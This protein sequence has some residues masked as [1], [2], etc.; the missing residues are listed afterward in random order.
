MFY[1]LNVPYTTN[2]GELQ[3]TLA[4]HA[5]LGYNTVVLSHTINGKLPG[6][7]TSPI[8]LP[9]PFPTS[10]NLH[11]LTRCTL[12]L[13]DPS[14]NHRLASLATNYDLLALRPTSEK[15]LQ[16]AC[17]HLPANS[18]DLISLDCS[19][20]YPFY[21]KHKPLLAAVDRGIR[22]EI[23]YA[24]GIL[25]TGDQRRNL[26]S[27]A[28]QLIR[29]TRGRGVVVSSEASRALACRGPWDVVNLCQ[30]WGLGRERGVEA[31]E[32]ESRAVVVGAEMRK[33]SFKGVVDVVFGGEKPVEK[34]GAETE[35][36]GKGQS[37]GTQNLKRKAEDEGVRNEAEKPLSKREM[38][39]RA[40]KAR[41]ETAVTQ[42]AAAAKENDSPMAD[43]ENAVDVSV[44][45]TEGNGPVIDFKV[46]AVGVVLG[47]V[48]TIALEEPLGDTL[49]DTAAALFATLVDAIVWKVDGW[50]LDESAACEVLAAIWGSTTGKAAMGHRH[51]QSQG[52]DATLDLGDTVG[53]A[54]D[55]S[56]VLA[57]V[58]E[59][60]IAGMAIDVESIWF[61]P[62]VTTDS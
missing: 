3:R 1:D 43:L 29:A 50:L 49:G 18:V 13:S 51:E 7:L 33:K 12:H 34:K 30:A 11:L 16:S 25:G 15:A 22:I 14:Q 23:C 45:I 2:Q 31:I 46:K 42:D 47:L 41:M 55:D 19:I 48:I 36:K 56:T 17:I 60:G 21:F 39:R 38:K 10:P 37:K 20:R 61:R 54:A 28:T 35:T 53:A 57:D 59:M 26:I 4:F 58:V 44:T 62:A 8:P 52:P 32:R 24:V 5:E 40:H 9:L 27:N 6:D